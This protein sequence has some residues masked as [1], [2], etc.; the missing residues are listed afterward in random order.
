MIVD[1]AYSVYLS[2]CVNC[3][4]IVLLFVSRLGYAVTRNIVVI[5]T[6]I[7]VFF[8]SHHWWNLV[9]IVT[10]GRG[11]LIGF[12]DLFTTRL[13]HTCLVK[14]GQ[15]FVIIDSSG[16]PGIGL[17][18]LNCSLVQ[19]LQIKD[20]VWYSWHVAITQTECS[21][22]LDVWIHK[23]SQGLKRFQRV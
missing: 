1:T 17:F 4:Y 13:K 19:D 20:S 2:S 7:I 22:G 11:A 6:W 10:D 12:F 21:F 5:S 15:Y 8:R 16:K 3:W 23:D 18:K 9:G 14:L